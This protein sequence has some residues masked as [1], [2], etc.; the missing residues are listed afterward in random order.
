MCIIINMKPIQFTISEDL[1]A[2]VDQD[3]EARRIG[4]S[5]FLR[6]A[7]QAYLGLRKKQEIREAYEKGY[8]EHPPENGE[9]ADWSEEQMWPEE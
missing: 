6:Q 5:A 9:L 2:R 7:I 3:P 4:R 1:L 8:G